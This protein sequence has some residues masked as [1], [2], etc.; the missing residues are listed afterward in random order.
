MRERPILHKYETIKSQIEIEFK[1][2]LEKTEQIKLQDWNINDL[3][4]VLKAL[5]LRQSR[6]TKGWANELFC[7][8][9]IG[10]NL[11]L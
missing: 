7:F 8:N 6:D 1:Y 2:I 3:N 4:I 5:K 9:N 10:K 11:K